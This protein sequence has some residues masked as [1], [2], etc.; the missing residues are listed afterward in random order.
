MKRYSQA[1]TVSFVLG[2]FVVLP[3]FIACSLGLLVRA[4]GPKLHLFRGLSELFQDD[5]GCPI[6]PLRAVATSVTRVVLAVGVSTVLGAIL[7]V[8]WCLFGRWRSLFAP[9][10]EFVRGLPITFLLVPLIPVVGLLQEDIPWALTCV[11]CSLI[12]GVCIADRASTIERDRLS[13]VRAFLGRHRRLWLIRHFYFHELLAGLAVGLRMII[14][15]GVILVGVLEYVSAGNNRPGFGSLIA[16]Y[17]E[18]SRFESAVLAAV[19]LYGAFSLVI[20]LLSQLIA[21]RLL[22][23]Q[24]ER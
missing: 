19:L 15:Y 2:L 6:R 23:W 10:I 1:Q 4:G 20:I 16:V 21:T 7:G 22:A 5:V 3:L 9:T 13:T 14:P 11:P 12:V 18:D 17:A 8:I 24:E